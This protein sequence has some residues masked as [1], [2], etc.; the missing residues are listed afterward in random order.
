MRQIQIQQTRNINISNINNPRHSYRDLIISNSGDV[1][2]LGFYRKCFFTIPRLPRHG[3]SNVN[4][5]RQL[6]AESLMI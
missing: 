2:H 6:A 4:T 1:S 5:N 3:I